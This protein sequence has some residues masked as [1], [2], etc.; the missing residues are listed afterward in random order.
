M[1]RNFLA[2]RKEFE[3][4]NVIDNF[5]F[6]EKDQVKTAFPH[7]YHG[8]DKLGRLISIQRMGRI[9]TPGLLSVTTVERLT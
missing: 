6:P 4:D 1:F 5:K 8:I 3:I 2:M 7:G 9:D